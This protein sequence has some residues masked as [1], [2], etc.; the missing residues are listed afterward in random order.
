M[1][2]GIF[3]V[4]WL[5]V[6]KCL[7]HPAQMPAK[8]QVRQKQPSLMSHLACH[9]VSL[10]YHVRETNE[11]QRSPHLPSFVACH[12][13]AAYNLSVDVAQ[14]SLI[15][16]V[17]TAFPFPGGLGDTPSRRR[18]KI[19]KTKS[20]CASPRAPVLYFFE[21]NSSKASQKSCCGEVEGMD[22]PAAVSRMEIQ[23]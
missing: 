22:A 12:P 23:R 7:C 8:I 2:L 3:V 15:C 20:V 17:A 19:E 21:K 14:A 1:C 9:P 5:F 18:Q 6:R 4:N 11:K 13:A 16:E 10:W